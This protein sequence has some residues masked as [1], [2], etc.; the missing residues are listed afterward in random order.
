M[1][2]RFPEIIGIDNTYKTNRFNMY[3]AQITAVTD[4]G[5]VAN[6]GFG[7]ISTQKEAGFEWLCIAFDIIRRKLDIKPPQV[8]ITDKGMALKNVARRV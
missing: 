6:I 3:L 7:L 2:P 1:W 4:Q 8:F 5:T